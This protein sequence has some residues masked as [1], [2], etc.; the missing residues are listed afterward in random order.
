MRT[1]TI[2][3]AVAVLAVAVLAGAARADWD[4]TMPFKYV[5]YP[6]LFEGLDV[7]ATAPKVLADDFPCNMTGAITDIHLWTSW[8]YDEGPQAIPIRLSIH[9]NVPAGPAAFSMPGAELWSRVFLPTEYT[10]K[11]IVDVPPEGWYDPNTGEY[12]PANH[13]NMYQYNF[14]INAAD[15]F[16]QQGTPGK[17]LI[18]W[19]DVSGLQLPEPVFGWKTSEDHW[20]DAAVFGHLDANNKPIGDWQPLYYPGT[21]RP[22]D[23]A[24]VITPEPATLAL[25]GLGVAG[26]LAR[27]RAR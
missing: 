20:M 8:K 22:L 11:Q 25:L 17:A 18:Y 15:A 2:A 26:I 13:L 19:L 14:K 5:Q 12:L 16:V 9:S 27:R 21:T 10:I 3:V 6:D 4:T 1:R 24:F 23:M 7:N